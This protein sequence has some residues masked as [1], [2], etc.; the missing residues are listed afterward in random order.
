MTRLFSAMRLAPFALTLTCAAALAAPAVQVTPAR[1]HPKIATQ[2]SGS[3][4]GANQAVDV[5]W[6]A[7]DMLVA[8][9]DASGAFPNKSISVPANALPGTHWISAIERV[10]G[11]A[12]QKAFIVGTAWLSHGFNERGRR[13]NPYENVIDASNVGNLDVA[14]AA[15]TGNQVFSSPAVLNGRVYVGSEDGKLYAFNSSTGA[16]AWGAPANPGGAILSSPAIA[17][18]GSAVYVGSNNGNLYAFNAVTGAA[19]WGAPAATGSS[20]ASSPAIANG[21]VYVGTEDGHLWAFNASTGAPA[22]ASPATTGQ[23]DASSP[24][25]AGGIVYVGSF[26]DGKLYAFDA[27]TG[28]AIP[29]WPVASV[30]QIDSSPT[31][32][33]GLVYVGAANNNLYAF[34]AKTAGAPAWVVS[35]A[36]FV[37][38]SPA[39]ANGVVY[40]GSSD[41]KLYAVNAGNGAVLWTGATGAEIEFSSPAVANGVVY[42]GSDDRKL[43]AFSAKGCGAPTCSPLWTATTGNLIDS[44]PA[45]SDGMVFVGS[46]DHSLYAYA[47]DAGNSAAYRYRNAPPPPYATLHPNFHLKPVKD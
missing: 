31:V 12:A 46:A 33:D 32:A 43:Y 25:V 18:S 19:A 4:F 21:I 8:V 41:E 14:W 29:G 17:P 15:A 20:I 13:R 22:W 45:V 40:V 7:T 28:T 24:A 30:S 23:I 26:G 10:D 34:N 11:K 3:G 37:E 16:P 47:L 6:D 39:V 9:T 38:S 42:I 36:G 5:Y 35:T 1:G 27:A 44:S 2:V